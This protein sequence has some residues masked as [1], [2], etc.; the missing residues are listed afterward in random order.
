MRANLHKEAENKQDHFS[1]RHSDMAGV[2][3]KKTCCL[4]KMLRVM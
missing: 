3:L 4:E 2:V 1:G